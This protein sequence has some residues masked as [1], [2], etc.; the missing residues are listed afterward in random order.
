[1]RIAAIIMAALLALSL[2]GCMGGGNDNNTA[3]VPGTANGGAQGGVN[4]GT[5]NGGAG[6]NGTSG[7]GGSAGMNGMGGSTADGTNGN[8]GGGVNGGADGGSNDGTGGGTQGGAANGSGGVNG[9]ANQPGSGSERRVMYNGELYEVTGEVLD[10]DEVG[11][12]LFSITS[13]VEGAPAADG[14]ASGLDEGTKVFRIRD[15]NEYDQIAVE[16]NDS[17]YRAIRRS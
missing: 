14:D 8:A 9:T 12:Q 13:V 2:T 10:S 6:A 16:I 7:T 1:M 15:D 17:Y 5:A 4:G 11:A 3:S